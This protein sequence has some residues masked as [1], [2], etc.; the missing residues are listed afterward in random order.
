MGEDVQQRLFHSVERFYR[1]ERGQSSRFRVKIMGLDITCKCEYIGFRAGS[2]SGFHYW[3]TIL[4][5]LNGIDLEKMVGFGGETAWTEGEAFYELL[6][7]SDC[8]DE[9]TPSQCRE[10]K[11]DFE[12]GYRPAQLLQL[13]PDKLERDYWEERF[14]N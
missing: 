8:E 7:H 5:A 9:L 13:I 10:L 12:K 6:N 2:Y 3:R 14:Q 11:A 4:A 1:E